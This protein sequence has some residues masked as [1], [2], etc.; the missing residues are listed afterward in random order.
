MTFPRHIIRARLA[1][2]RA[3]MED[4]ARRPGQE[5]SVRVLRGEVARLEAL[6]AE[7]SA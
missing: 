4:H 1:S 7:A 2:T 6:L 3:L 5:D